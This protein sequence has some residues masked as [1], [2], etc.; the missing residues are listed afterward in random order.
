MKTFVLVY[1]GL[2]FVKVPIEAASPEDALRLW[3]E[4]LVGRTRE[5]IVDVP[6]HSDVSIL[7]NS[8]RIVAQLP[9]PDP[10]PEY[11]EWLGF[12]VQSRPIL[13]E[14]GFGVVD[15]IESTHVKE[16]GTFDLSRTLDWWLGIES[17][18]KRGSFQSFVERPQPRQVAP[19][20]PGTG[21]RWPCQTF[22]TRIARRA[23]AL[24]ARLLGRQ[25]R[26]EAGC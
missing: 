8:G 23:R 24:V 14:T 16:S 22:F 6:R 18:Q 11:C 5:V 21:W 2:A 15:P 10:S 1:E 13:V 4:D 26:E 17:C 20:A 25:R 3:R 12:Q 19:W 9:L 7:D